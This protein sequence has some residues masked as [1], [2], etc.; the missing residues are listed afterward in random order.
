VTSSNNDGYV[1]RPQDIPLFRY[2]ALGWNRHGIARE[3][4]ISSGNANNLT[5]RLLKRLN[6]ASKAEAVDKA[7]KNRWLS[8]PEELTDLVAHAREI[9]FEAS[10]IE[11]IDQLA[12]G[13]TYAQIAAATASTAKIVQK[14]IINLSQ[15]L[16]PPV[17]GRPHAPRI[18]AIVRFATDPKIQVGPAKILFYPQEKQFLVDLALGTTISAMAERHSVSRG[19]MVRW[20]SPTYKKLGASRRTEAVHVALAS[21]LLTKEDLP[22]TEA[23]IATTAALPFAPGQLKNLQDAAEGKGSKQL[24]EPCKLAR[25]PPDSLIARLTL[26]GVIKPSAKTEAL[27]GKVVLTSI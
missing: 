5:A 22:W 12:A 15:K 11:L 1:P 20:I 14:R 6:V 9:G 7:I 3:L 25:L 8:M 2:F 19:T 21:D 10:E 23:E 26:A 4:G 16:Y 13:Q 24:A 27:R 18:V 17:Q